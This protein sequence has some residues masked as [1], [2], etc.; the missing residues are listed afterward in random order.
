[1]T[2]RPLYY[3]KVTQSSS[4]RLEKGTVSCS[5]E[6]R[7][8]DRLTRTLLATVTL[9]GLV[10]RQRIPTKILQVGKQPIFPPSPVITHCSGDNITHNSERCLQCQEYASRSDF[11]KNIL[12]F[13][14]LVFKQKSDRHFCSLYQQFSLLRLLVLRLC[15][16]I[17]FLWPPMLQ[18]QNKRTS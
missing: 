4:G 12:S 17:M 15:G 3:R 11:Y 1:M 8:L 18:W 9:P 6:I 14:L 5:A 2:P 13:F 16:H 7:N 10:L